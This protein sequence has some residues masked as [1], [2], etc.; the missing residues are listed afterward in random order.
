LSSIS[1]NFINIPI[2]QID[3]EISKALRTI[4]NITK[5]NR[6]SIYLIFEDHNYASKA[7]EWCDEETISNQFNYQNIPVIKFP[8][9]LSKMINDENLILN[10]S[11]EIPR[12]AKNERDIWES[13]R[14]KSMMAVPLKSKNK[15]MGMLGAASLDQQITFKEEDIFLVKTAG[16]IIFNTLERK[17]FEIE[18]KSSEE[19]YST[20]FENI[21]DGIIYYDFI[22]KKVVKSNLAYQKLSG[23]TAEEL[24]TLRFYDL[25]ANDH[26]TIHEFDMLLET[27]RK[28]FL[29]ERLHRK[30]DGTEFPVEV[31]AN[32]I[33]LDGREV[34]VVV[35]RDITL[36]KKNEIALAESEKK[37]R[38]LFEMMA[39]G[40]VFQNIEGEIESA[41]PSACRILG[42]TND[43]I[44]DG[45]SDNKY[46][47]TIREDGNEFSSIDH[48]A[49]VALR[50]GKPIYDVIMGICNPFDGKI[51]WLVVNTIPQFNANENKPFGVFTTFTDISERK[52][53]EEILKKSEMELRKLNATKDKF[54]S[55]VAHDLKSPFQGLLGASNFLHE[56]LDELDNKDIKKFMKNISDATKNIYNLIEQLLDWS[57]L[58]SG[59]FD[60]KPEKLDL[61][62]NLL[63]VINL[64][65]QT[66]I[67]KKIKIKHTIESSIM[68]FTDER[69]LNSVLQN[70]ISNAI[71]FTKPEGS[72]TISTIP[73]DNFVVVSVKDTG[74][75]I[76]E[77]ALESIFKIDANRSTRGTQGEEGT[78]LGLI[79]CKEMIQRWGGN[80]WV[81]SK[82]NK[83]SSF[84]FTMLKA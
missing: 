70:L 29:G 5:A 75:G 24:L 83:G 82:I 16:E 55:I 15:L 32:L 84:Y 14:V 19:Q 63:Y 34:L 17:K 11:S 77:D 81:E 8:W 22:T 69:M 3:E 45:P 65:G 43:L 51:R 68:V 48:P 72:I 23:Y 71:K 9:I 60:F 37:Y 4:G 54:F 80:I 57:R 25:I 41:N 7:Y 50:T 12:I 53:T 20:V 52:Q 6:V 76:K 35:V 44:V 56:N 26:S 79:L 59:H 66:A 46:W 33:S 31:G 62:H 58:Q 49:F 78:G 36:R 13:E 67:A 2:E 61:L 42:I 73:D 40:V 10:D 38:T 21:S 1:T 28:Y 47:R 18:L 30:K 64:V 39:Q 74:V 27:H